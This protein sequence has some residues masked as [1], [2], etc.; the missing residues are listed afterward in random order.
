MS[1]LLLHTVNTL[2]STDRN[3]LLP[4]TTLGALSSGTLRCSRILAP[5]HLAGLAAGPAIEAKRQCSNWAVVNSLVDV[6][7]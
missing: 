5:A 1:I 3:E 6:T 4:P 7:G 2:S